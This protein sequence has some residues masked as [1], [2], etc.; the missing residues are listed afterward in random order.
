MGAQVSDGD[1]SKEVLVRVVRKAEENMQEYATTA[2]LIETGNRSPVGEAAVDMNAC[3]MQFRQT[4]MSLEEDTAASAQI[5]VL[6]TGDT[7]VICSV[8]CSTRSGSATPA[9]YDDRPAVETSRIF[10]LRGVTSTACTVRVKDDVQREGDELFSVHLSRPQVEYSDVNATSA[11]KAKRAAV[12]AVAKMTIRIR[13]EEDVT[14]VRFNQSTYQAVAPTASS[15]S[16]ILTVQ[17]VRTGDLRSPTKVS[18]QSKDGSARANVDYAPLTSSASVEF[19]A[20]EAKA[21]IQLLLFVRAG[22]TKSFTL[23]IDSNS[24]SNAQLANPH[25]ATVIVPTLASIGPTVLPSEPIVVSLMHY[26]I[27]IPITKNRQYFTQTKRSLHYSHLITIFLQ[28]LGKFI[29]KG[30]L[31]FEIETKN[32]RHNSYID[33]VYFSWVSLIIDSS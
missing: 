32:L 17:L 30:T 28:N 33:Y 13:D 11:G 18:I 10:F 8:L 12:G 20:N 6:R 27:F 5:A 16:T 23:F 7:S 26:G 21:T 25:T 4:E 31:N 15:N 1:S 19:K 29:Y 22:W 3:V 2:P 9:D 24:L 14:R